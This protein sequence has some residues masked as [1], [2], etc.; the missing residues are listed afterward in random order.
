[1][2]TCPLSQ[3]RLLTKVP[4]FP[5]RSATPGVTTM[6]PGHPATTKPTCDARDAGVLGRGCHLVT[7][8]GSDVDVIRGREIQMCDFCPVLGA[9]LLWGAA[10][11]VCRVSPV[12]SADLHLKARAGARRAGPPQNQGWRFGDHFTV[13]GG[14]R[15]R[16]CK[17]STA[18][19]ETRASAFANTE[20]WGAVES[21]PVHDEEASV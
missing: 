2:P 21:W 16:I 19:H 11:Q 7:G 20:T 3:E 12:S 9:S 17:A 6:L 8:Q 14:Y 15:G 5:P 1:M 18:P 13:E 4:T 10:L